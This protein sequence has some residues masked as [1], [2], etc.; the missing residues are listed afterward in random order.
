MPS[1]NDCLETGPSL[2]PHIFD[3]LLR[4]RMKKYCI[5]GDVRKA[6]L[7]IK[8]DPVDRDAQRLFWYNNLEERKITAYRFTRVIF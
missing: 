6:F 8:L 5:T 4:N 7:Q 3:I 2:Q 1:L